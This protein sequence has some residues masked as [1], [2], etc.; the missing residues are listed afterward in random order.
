[1]RNAHEV[2]L[3]EKENCW[4]L[5]YR[6]DIAQC[7]KIM[8][9]AP[10]IKNILDQIFVQNP[11]K[12]PGAASIMKALERITHVSDKVLA[13]GKGTM[14]VLAVAKAATGMKD[15]TATA[16]DVS[17]RLTSI[18][19][20]NDHSLLVACVLSLLSLL[21]LAVCIAR[22]LRKGEPVCPE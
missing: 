15:P 9:N 5:D 2:L 7:K 12:R 18:P 13:V 14:K 1:M 21:G 16:V 3:R 6:K 8:E 11:Q 19:A 20:P 22:S 17:R 10:R 4:L